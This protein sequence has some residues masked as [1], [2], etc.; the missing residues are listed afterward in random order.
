MPKFVPTWLL[1]SAALAIA[2]WLLGDHMN[3]GDSGDSTFAR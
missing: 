2:A 1:S 3:I